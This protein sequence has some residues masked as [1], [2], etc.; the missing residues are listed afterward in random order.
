MNINVQVTGL[1]SGPG[2]RTKFEPALEQV[3][4]LLSQNKFCGDSLFVEL[5]R[6]LL[7]YF[8][9]YKFNQWNYLNA[10]SVLT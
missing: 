10:A 8:I 4:L 1:E 7:D 5:L 6:L 3:L 9:H 2:F